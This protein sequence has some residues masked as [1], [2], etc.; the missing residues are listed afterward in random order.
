[1]LLFDHVRSPPVADARNLADHVAVSRLRLKF[2]HFCKLLGAA[3]I[4]LCISTAAKSAADQNPQARDLIVG[5]W[6]SAGGSC[7]SDL[8]ERYM[9]KGRFETLNSSGTWS[10]QGSQLIVR[11]TNAGEM[12]EA[13]APV[14]P[15]H[16]TVVTLVTI[17]QRNRSERWPDGSVRWAIRCR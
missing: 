7:D 14:S 16:T 13:L 9:P 10:L 2:E 6:S 4:A 17:N 11:V 12:G 3:G 15:A 5:T 1:M 8:R